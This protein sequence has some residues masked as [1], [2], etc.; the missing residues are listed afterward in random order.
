M[1]TVISYAQTNEDII[2][3][4]ALKGESH[5]FYIDIGANDPD[6][7]S[8]TKFFYENDIGNGINVE[9][10]VKYKDVYET[11]RSRDVN[12][13]CGAGNSAGSMDLYGEDT[14]ASFVFEREKHKKK[15]SIPIRTLSDI[16]DEYVQGKSEPIHFLKIDVEGFEKQVIEGMDFKRYRPWVIA[17]ESDDKEYMDW[18]PI[19][20]ENEY[21]FAI[22]HGGSRFYAA[23]ERPE[24]YRL[25]CECEKLDEMYKIASMAQYDTLKINYDKLKKEYDSI[26]NSLC[27]R[28]TAPIRK[29]GRSK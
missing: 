8:V 9:P 19:L 27:W 12:L 11:K 16:C 15:V 1:E 5:I 14:G 10:Q 18:E 6:W 3:Y 17:A 20:V 26:V 2:L 7:L 25:L 22:E 21:K 4:H 29:F 24:Q 23:S 13:F 28:M